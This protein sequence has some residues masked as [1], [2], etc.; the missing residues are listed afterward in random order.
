MLRM[1]YTS[2]ANQHNDKT[3][4]YG[5]FS[6]IL[7]VFERA[8]LEP[9]TIQGSELR[10]NAS[11]NGLSGFGLRHGSVDETDVSRKFDTLTISQTHE[12]PCKGLGQKHVQ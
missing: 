6:D 5:C 2:S 8:G 12:D 4:L 9:I 7:D 11:P 1:D 3:H 10:Y